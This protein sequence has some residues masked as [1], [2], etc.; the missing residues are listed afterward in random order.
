V[1]VAL[2]ERPPPH[3]PGSATIDTPVPAGASEVR[4]T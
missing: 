1:P 2:R 3:G 4:M